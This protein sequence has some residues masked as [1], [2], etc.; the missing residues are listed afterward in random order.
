MG[1]MDV[2]GGLKVDLSTAKSRK[3]SFLEVSWECIRELM[4]VFRSQCLSVS[5]FWIVPRF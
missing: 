2:S 4:C 3:I 1:T 5:V